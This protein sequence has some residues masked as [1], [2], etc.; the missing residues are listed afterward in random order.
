MDY[1]EAIRL[2]ERLYDRLSARRP[3]SQRLEAYYRGEHPLAF[4]TEEWRKAHERRY[5]GFADNWCSP[6]VDAET[7]RLTVAGIKVGDDRNAADRLWRFWRHNEG[8]MQSSQGWVTTLTTGRSFVTVWGPDAELTWEHPDLVE[9]E[10]DPANWRRRRA[11]LRT[12]LDDETEFAELYTSTHVWKFQRPRATRH[13]RRMPQRTAARPTQRGATGWRP[14]EVRD[15][16]WPLPHPMGAV[17]IVEVL[18]RPL[19]VGEPI[20]EIRG[21]SAMQDAINL[22]WAYL[23]SAADFAAMPGRVITGAQPP[24]LPILDKDGEVIGKRPLEM[25]VLTSKRFLTLTGDNAKIA[26]WSAADLSA[27]TDVIEKAIAHIAAQ[28]RT[29]P[30][31]LISHTGLSNVSSE[32]LKASEIGLVK[33]TLEFQTFAEPSLREVFR[34]MAVADGEPGLEQAARDMVIAWADPEIRSESQMGDSLIKKKAIGYPLEYLLELD[35]HEPQEVERILAMV[36]QEA[37]DP[38]IERASRALDGLADADVRSSTA[39]SAA[40]SGDE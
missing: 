8:E 20:S 21:A 33:K 16:P 39:P 4:A 11:A 23:L 29:P 18:N 36:E 32:G 17:P 25:D 34:L 10:Y 24:S 19:L 37:L 22:L 12:W 5:R 14:L 1:S 3:D 9:V 28:T 40:V 7:E 13:N 35:G 27:F 15:E 38:M 30:T 6:I 2:V 26:E 31:Y